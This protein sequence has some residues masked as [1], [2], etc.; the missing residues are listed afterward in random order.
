MNDVLTEPSAAAVAVPSGTETI[1]QQVPVQ[2]TRLP[3]TVAQSSETGLPGSSPVA[4]TPTFALTA[5]AVELSFIATP[6]G[7]EPRGR[8]SSACRPSAGR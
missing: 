6:V 5:L 2:F 1:C 7:A 8:R 4:V 3:T